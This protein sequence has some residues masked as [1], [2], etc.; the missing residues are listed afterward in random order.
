[1]KSPISNACNLTTLANCFS[2]N[3]GLKKRAMKFRKMEIPVT[4]LPLPD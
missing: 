3:I 2:F 4:F 1:M